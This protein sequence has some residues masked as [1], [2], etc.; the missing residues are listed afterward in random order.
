[1]FDIRIVNGEVIIKPC[2]TCN[3]LLPSLPSLC[4]K[5]G[6]APPAAEGIKTYVNSDHRQ[7]LIY[8]VA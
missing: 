2:F 8:P 4:V 7:D 1:M 6:A 5:V 3:T